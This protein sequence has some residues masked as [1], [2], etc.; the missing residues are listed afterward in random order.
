M[1]RA[2][3]A[4]GAT[5]GEGRLCGGVLSHAPRLRG[6]AGCSRT[7]KRTDGRTGVRPCPKGPN[8]ELSS[9]RESTLL[10]A[11]QAERLGDEQPRLL[12]PP[13][14]WTLAVVSESS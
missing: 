7:A 12:S 8:T 5:G 6:C 4:G 2:Y 9:S 11:W 1:R 10:G 3:G 13:R 14:C